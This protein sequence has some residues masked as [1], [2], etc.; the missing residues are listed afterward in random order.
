MHV[1]SLC[2]LG[3]RPHLYMFAEKIAKDAERTEDMIN[4]CDFQRRTC[5]KR[6]RREERIKKLTEQYVNKEIPVSTF[7]DEI[8]KM[9]S[10]ITDE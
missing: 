8:A 5:E 6:N 4:A 1:C 10:P 3:A 7:L 9:Y 2:T